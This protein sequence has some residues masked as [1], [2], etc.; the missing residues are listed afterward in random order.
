MAEQKRW[1]RKGGHDLRHHNRERYRPWKSTD[2]ISRKFFDGDIS[3]NV[4]L[5]ERKMKN[6]DFAGAEK[7]V[8]AVLDIHP[9]HSYAL[10]CLL[11]IYS[12]TDR[13]DEARARYDEEIKPGRVDNRKRLELC[14]AMIEIY[15]EHDL[16]RKAEEI[17]KFA[18]DNGLAN[19]MTYLKVIEKRK[20]LGSRNTWKVLESIPDDM[21]GKENI[22]LRLAEALR[23]QKRHEE[24][25]EIVESIL[26][27][28]KENYFDENY[29]LARIV[30]A[31]CLKGIGRN[32]EAFHEFV[33]LER[34]VPK[35]SAHYGRVLCGWAFCAHNVSPESKS[36]MLALL[37][38]LKE[39]CST[40][41]LKDID[42]AMRILK[43]R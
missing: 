36:R 26:K 7:L 11:R 42:F 10:C 32:E 34:N 30:K 25:I 33:E 22:S 13:L 15:L 23:K 2:W 38:A 27:D 9:H 17:F 4:K 40:R 31:H 14:N 19:E 6:R 16:V 29:L 35:D 1:S 3:K 41:L 5:A 18:V 28:K 8:L 21:K 12:E 39:T 20:N 37:G 43:K 24:A